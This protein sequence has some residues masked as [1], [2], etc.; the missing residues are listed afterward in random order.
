[1]QE[2]FVIRLQTREWATQYWIVSKTRHRYHQ[3]STG[4][5][6]YLLW[7][8]IVH[9]YT[10]KINCFFHWTNFEYMEKF[11][12]QG[13]KKVWNNSRPALSLSSLLPFPSPPLL[14]PFLPSFFSLP[15]PSPLVPSFSLP[16][17]PPLR[18]RVQGL[19][20]GVNSGGSGNM[21]ARSAEKFSGFDPHFL[22]SNPP[23]SG[24]SVNSGVRVNVA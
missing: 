21:S 3:F 16:F 10:I 9:K 15:L 17:P 11:T 24:K 14:F 13:L 12:S 8:Q 7:T 18:S 22:Y 2:D 19:R 4:E 23:L 6:I 20:P 1:M 5:S